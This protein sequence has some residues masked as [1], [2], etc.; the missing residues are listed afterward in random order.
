VRSGL[1]RTSQSCVHK[2]VHNSGSGSTPHGL[3]RPGVLAFGFSWEAL[4][5]K[6]DEDETQSFLQAEAPLT[7]AQKEPAEAIAE[8]YR[9][10]LL[11][12]RQAAQ[13]PP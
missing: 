12:Q 9:E 1:L 13:P 3:P 8:K 11:E 2:C 4:H 10:Q 7:D 5:E 6:L